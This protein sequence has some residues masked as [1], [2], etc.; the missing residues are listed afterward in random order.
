MNGKSGRGN[1]RHRTRKVSAGRSVVSG[2]RMLAKYKSLIPKPLVLIIADGWGYARASKGN[3]IT[4]AKTPN[5]DNYWRNY[6]HCLLEASGE[7]VGLPKG[8]VGGSEVGHFTIGAGR[9]VLQE[10]AVIDAAVKDGSFFHDKELLG[11]MVKARDA[12]HDLH[13]MGL[14]SDAG[15]HAHTCHL[16]ALLKMAKQHRLSRVF[17]HAFTD[18]RDVP[19]KS[20]HKYLRRLDGLFKRYKV[21]RLASI[22]GRYYAMDRD[23]NWDRT[24]IA[25]RMLVEGKGKLATDAMREI[26]AQ[27]KNGVMSD[28][29]LRPI[30]MSDDGKI[31]RAIIKDGDSAIFYNYRS[32]RSRQLTRAFWM[33]R[34][35]EFK[36]RKHRAVNFVCLAQYDDRLRKIPVAFPNK[37]I[38]QNLAEILSKRG[39]WQLR[40]AETEK[41]AHA[42]FFFNSQRNKSYPKEKRV[43]VKSL[44]TPSYADRPEMSAHEITSRLLTELNKQGYDFVLVNFANPDLVGHSGNLKAAIKAVSIVD[45]CAGVVVQDVLTRDGVII[46]SADHGNADEMLYPSGEPNPGHSKNPVPFILISK[47]ARQYHLCKK[48]G[49]ADIAPT[50]LELLG[51]SKPK[52]MTGKSLLQ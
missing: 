25:Y 41:Y 36:P 14:L 29:Y 24:K 50:I 49:L 47:N 6:P 35:N 8:A 31:P 45:K 20:L 17:V 22:V 7:A 9:V 30:I 37:I 16:E 48:G 33:D 51:L 23:N 10:L 1:V 12:N 52:I 42:T 32:D 18:G 4:L 3:A 13:I 11:A 40:V 34:F 44:K 21:G 28:Y 26:T 46:F 2:R 19:E 5:F 27:Y 39:K 15:V 43:L 38:R